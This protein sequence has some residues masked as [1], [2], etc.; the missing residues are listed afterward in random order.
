MNLE[1][2]VTIDAPVA[3]VWERI[4]DIENAVE[5]IEAI[6][7]IEIL[8]KPDSGLVG[9]KWRETRT[10]F[11]KKA[12]EV[13]WVTEAKENELYRTRAE[14]HGCI[15]ISSLGVSESDDG[16]SLTMSHET[17]PQAFMAKIMAPL[18]GLLFKGAF[19]KMIRKDLEDLKKGLEG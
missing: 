11:G 17:Q 2:K 7:E 5:N 14:S 1:V 8:E 18:M 16:T 6:E 10:V 12:T 19:C 9:L 15:Y 4:T 13:M 3:A